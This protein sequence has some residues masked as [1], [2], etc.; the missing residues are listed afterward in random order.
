VVN[1]FIRAT[2]LIIRAIIM[3]YENAIA[4]QKKLLTGA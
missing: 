2:T 3:I 1:P 4:G